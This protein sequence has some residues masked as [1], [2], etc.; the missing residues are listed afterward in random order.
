MG[1]WKF[2]LGRLRLG[3]DRLYFGYERQFYDRKDKEKR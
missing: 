2:R 3:F 1:Y